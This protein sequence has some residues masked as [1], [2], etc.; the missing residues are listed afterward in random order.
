[1]VLCESGELLVGN[2]CLHDVVGGK[3]TNRCGRDL[4]SASFA[5]HEPKRYFQSILVTHNL[6]GAEPIVYPDQLR[7]CCRHPFV[8]QLQLGWC[9]VTVG[10]TRIRQWPK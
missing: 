4:S 3:A 2:F 8:Q 9:I 7:F 6:V 5:I 10:W 1:M